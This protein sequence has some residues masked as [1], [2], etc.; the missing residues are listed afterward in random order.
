MGPRPPAFAFVDFADPRDAEDA[1]RGR[2][3]YSYA[4]ERLRVELSRSRG[5]GGSGPGG[6]D[7]G[8][9]DRDRDAGGGGGRN[10]GPNP[11]G[12]SRRTD[13]RVIVTN[14]PGSCSWQDLKDHMRRAGEVTFSQVR[15]SKSMQQV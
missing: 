4:G 13:Y 12:P 3:G 14:L 10:L 1:I 11:Y 6:R 2:D 15:L 5:P 7:A 8:G 9:R